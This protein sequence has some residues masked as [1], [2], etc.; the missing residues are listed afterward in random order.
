[1]AMQHVAANSTSIITLSAPYPPGLARASIAA[2]RAVRF[3]GFNSSFVTFPADA[4]ERRALLSLPNTHLKLEALDASAYYE[5]RAEM[6]GRRLGGRHGGGVVDVP[7]QGSMG[8]YYTCAAAAC[9]HHHFYFILT[10][11]CVCRIAEVSTEMSRLVAMYPEWLGPAERVGTTRQGRAIE[12]WCLAPGGASGC[13]PGNTDRPS[14]LFTSLVHAREPATLMCL[15]HALRSL[16]KDAAAHVQSVRQMLSARRLLWMPI[17]NPDGYAW[18]E[19][20]R[21]RGGGMKRKNGMRCCS[22]P[23]GENDG[24]DLNRNFG[25]K[26]AY[27]NIGSQGRGCSEEYRG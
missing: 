9:N 4:D 7:L 18:N 6:P 8:G 10:F 3:A 17:A 21:P 24:V 1:M 23:D 11:S 25:Y 15:I 13:A 14:V 16:L 19:R 20:M 12:V 26:W 5:S 2:A 27:D 22:P